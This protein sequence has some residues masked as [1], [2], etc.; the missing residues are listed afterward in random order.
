MSKQQTNH[1]FCEALKTLIIQLPVRKGFSLKQA[2]KLARID[3]YKYRQEGISPMTLSLKNYCD[4]FQIDPAWLI[5][6]ADEV[7]T[8]RLTE[9]R[10]LEILLR[11]PQ[12]KGR[13]ETAAGIA[14]DETIKELHV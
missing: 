7:A 2:S 1:E 4:T 9:G 3:L 13:F 6:L 10:A 12:F 14:I 11:W 5:R 8:K